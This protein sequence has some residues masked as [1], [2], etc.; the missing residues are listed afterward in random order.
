[1]RDNNQRLFRIARSI[2]KNDADAEDVVQL[3]YLSAYCHWDQLARPESAQ[4]WLNRIVCN[5][6]LD[7]VRANGRMDTPLTEFRDDHLSALSRKPSPEVEMLSSEL[8]SLLQ[9]LIERLPTE[10]SS[11]LVMRDVQGMSSVDVSRALDIGEGTVRVRLHR[12][13]RTLKKWMGHQLEEHLPQTYAFAGER[14]DRIVGNTLRAVQEPHLVER[15][16]EPPAG[17]DAGGHLPKQH[18]RSAWASWPVLSLAIVILAGL[19]AVVT[20]S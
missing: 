8:R 7:R 6:D 4:A 13:R 5:Q 3:A 11:V 19:I 20:L 15:A 18:G 12:A 1:M 2:V 10:L 17:W 14:C 16:I 9:R